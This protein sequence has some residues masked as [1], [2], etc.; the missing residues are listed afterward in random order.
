MVNNPG[1]AI[2]VVPSLRRR[3][4]HVISEVGVSGPDLDVTFYFQV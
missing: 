2:C 4:G 1:F 3:V